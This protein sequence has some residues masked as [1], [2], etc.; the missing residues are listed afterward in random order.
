MSHTSYS[1]N[2]QRRK[3]TLLGFLRALLLDLCHFLLHSSVSFTTQLWILKRH[4]RGPCCT[5]SDSFAQS[6][7]LNDNGRPRFKYL[8][9]GLTW[10]NCL[11]RIRGWVSLEEL[12]HWRSLEEQ[13]PVSSLCLLP[14]DQVA[15]SQLLL[16]YLLCHAAHHHDN[17]LES[18]GTIS[19]KKVF[20]KLPWSWH[21]FKTI[22]VRHTGTYIT[23]P[24]WSWTQ[25][26][27]IYIII[28]N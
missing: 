9:L 6:G 18:S 8:M 20:D 23:A 17:E 14:A 15:S 5:G 3:I 12:C 21:L 2:S 28:N 7:G 24:S 4:G 1:N 25:D 11:G 27:N 26:L 13:F 22:G 19:L 10:W 16:P